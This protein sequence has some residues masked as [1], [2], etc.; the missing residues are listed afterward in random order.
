MFR[1]IYALVSIVSA[2]AWKGFVLSVLCN[3]F[4][5]PVISFNFSIPFCLGVTVIYGLLS[6]D[7]Q[8]DTNSRTM[9]DWFASTLM[10]PA[11]ALLMG[12]IVKGFL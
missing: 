11:L 9:A 10:P 2:I 3:W 5:K 1:I 8:N 12:F 6:G 4:L 7:D